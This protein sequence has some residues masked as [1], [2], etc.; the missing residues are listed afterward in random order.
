MRTPHNARP[1]LLWIGFG[2]QEVCS[3]AKSAEIRTDFQRIDGVAI[4]G[5]FMDNSLTLTSVDRPDGEKHLIGLSL[6]PNSSGWLTR[7]Q[8]LIKGDWT[9]SNNI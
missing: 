2:Q 6:V 8:R 4:C 3:K 1:L 5:S 9:A 7:R